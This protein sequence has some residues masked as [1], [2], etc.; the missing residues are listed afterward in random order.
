MTKTKNIK[1]II[2]EAV[3]NS[4]SLPSLKNETNDFKCNE[5]R[6][7]TS[8]EKFKMKTKIKRERE[9]ETDLFLVRWRSS[10]EN[11]FDFDVQDRSLY[12]KKINIRFSPL[13][14]FSELCYLK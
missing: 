6:T 8:N 12:W 7:M 2:K 5:N 14:I 4:C 11:V 1:K 13:N 3:L 9:R 10:V